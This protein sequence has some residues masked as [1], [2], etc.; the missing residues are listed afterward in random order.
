M[1]LSE[2]ATK[3][4]DRADIVPARATGVLRIDLGAIAS[5]WRSLARLVAPAHC[6][7]VVKADA[8]GLGA[9]EV[10]PALAAAG[11]RTF[12]V[13]TIDEAVRAKALAPGA[14]VLVLDGLLT[15]SAADMAATGAIPVLSS[16]AEVAA[17]AAAGRAAGVKNRCALHVDTGL[18]R[19]G[20]AAREVHALAGDM[21]FLSAL[22]VRLVMS[23][24]ACADD[25]SSPK[26]AQ[27][28]EVFERLLPMLPSVPLSLAASDGLML[29]RP[30]HYDLVRPGYALYGGQAFGGG[31]T[32]VE[33]VVEL[34]VKVLQV[35]DVAP[36]Q[37]VGYGASW[38]ARSPSRIAIV[39]AGYADGL[40][41][42]LSRASDAGERA[43]AKTAE[44]SGLVGPVDNANSR[45]PR[46]WVGI[47]GQFAPIVGRVSMDLVTIDVSDIDGGVEPG[48]FVE[49]IGPNLPI[50]AMG[51]A[52][53]TIGY[54]VLT[55]LGRR[56]HRVYVGGDA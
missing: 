23:H 11:C 38:V 13:A 41:R 31:R 52:A 56:F 16:L 1:D 10:I 37:S 20:L 6:A 5:N 47:R 2:T 45:R 18:N 33:P 7:A 55:S 17:W 25:P 48:D 39:A 3:A 40:F 22:D 24:L 42:R 27:Q 26:N 44:A 8:Y 12:F 29:G 50:E 43:G 35:R 30:Y 9:A 54:E 15:G 28:R 51:T 21:H 14:A 53:G 49:V 36:G 32:P 34:H 46:A 19:L 4:S